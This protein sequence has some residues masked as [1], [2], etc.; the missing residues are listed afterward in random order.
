MYSYKVQCWAYV[1]G[2]AEQEVERERERERERDCVCV[3]RTERENDWAGGESN[4]RERTKPSENCTSLCRTL[5]YYV[6]SVQTRPRRVKSDLQAQANGR[7]SLKRLTCA[8]CIR[9]ARYTTPHKYT[10]RT[11]YCANIKCQHVN[12]LLGE[13]GDLKKIIISITQITLSDCL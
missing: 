2:R 11:F 1:V 10:V 12:F 6:E 4:A 9:R 8:V 3:G 5:F 7:C 13:E